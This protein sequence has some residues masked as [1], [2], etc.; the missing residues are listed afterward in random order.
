MGALQ[1]FDGLFAQEGSRPDSLE[2]NELNIDKFS[3]DFV[4]SRNSNNKIISIYGD[5]IWD[6]KP[7]RSN[8][9]QHAVI[10]FSKRVK[11][12]S[13]IKE[14]KKIMMLLLLFGSGRNGS[15]YSVETTQHFFNDAVLL[16]SD[17]ALNR[18]IT[19]KTL[20][21][22]NKLLREFLKEKCIHRGKIQAVSSLLIFLNNL[23]NNI[24]R[25]NFTKD[26]ELFDEIHNLIKRFNRKITQTNVI[27]SRILRESIK[28]RWEQIEE[29]ENNIDNILLFLKMYLQDEQ[30]AISDKTF[31]F[32]FSKMDDKA[33]VW[34]EAL[35]L[36][37]LS[38]FFSQ[39]NVTNR[40]T[41]QG[42]ITSIYGTSKHLIHMYTGMRSGEVLM[43]QNECIKTENTKSGVCHIISTTSK[44]EGANKLSKWTTTKELKKVINLLIKINKVIASHYNIDANNMPL[45]IKGSFITSSEIKSI[46]TSQL[47]KR[48]FGLKD[49]F[50][51]S[52]NILLITGSD[53]KEFEDINYGSQ[54]SQIKVGET[55][56]FKSHQYRRSLAVYA[57]QSGLVSL[58][59]LQIQFKHL[60]REMTLYY[61]NGASYAKKLFD[62]SKDHIANDFD[63][64]KPE[65][66]TLE[67]IKNVIFSDEQLFGTHG[68]FVERNIKNKE[69]SQ[70]NYILENREKT[71]QQFKNGEITYKET[72]LG[73]CISTEACDYSLTRSIVA[74]GGCD[75]SIIKK[76][77]LDNV[78]NKQKEFIEFLDKDSIEYRTEMRDLEELEKQRKLFLGSKA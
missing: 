26:I 40:R 52:K 32:H 46:D 11:V 73:G 5:N 20:L 4:I 47:A 57:I 42:F 74:C 67:Y 14:C 34:T 54:N 36:F 60:F 68:T 15:R 55:W 69:L 66:E 44:L 2:D 58:G 70:K 65:I 3:L 62:V 35:E 63:K 23:D 12:E 61:A 77:K 19:I 49:E 13:Y 28:A 21:E 38:E 37:H 9:S 27:P 10:D 25:I 75:S 64:L 30:F 7:Y 56:I 53:V 33:V 1:L 41:F 45:F 59:A 78:I 71:L 16:L 29:I 31:K 6:L 17:F 8:P 76:S 51:L 43:L 22:D 72:S 24:S 50:P 48:K 18:K 39:Y